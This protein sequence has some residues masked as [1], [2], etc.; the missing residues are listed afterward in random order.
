MLRGAA[1][2]IEKRGNSDV[3]DETLL[4]ALAPMTDAI[5]VQLAADPST[6]SS[7]SSTIA[8]A[9][10][11][12]TRRRPGSP[13]MSI[14]R[15]RPAWRSRR[16]VALMVN[17]LGGTPISELY[18]VHRRAH[19][20]LADVASPWAATTSASTARRWTWQVPRSR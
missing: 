6:A 17:G 20:Q 19:N 3:G 4:D 15:R 13:W 12:F 8:P 5:V 11:S 14:P 9:G 1:E 18:L 16:P 2:G 7:S 10:I